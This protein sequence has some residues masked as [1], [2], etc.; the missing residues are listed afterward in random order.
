MIKYSLLIF[1]ITGAVDIGSL[2][3][4]SSNNKTLAISSTGVGSVSLNSKSGES[5]RS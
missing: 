2:D 1:I 5:H 3:F 4:F